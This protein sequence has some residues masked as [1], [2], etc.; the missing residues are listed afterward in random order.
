MLVEFYVVGTREGTGGGR[1]EPLGG[2][3]IGICNV[4]VHLPIGREIL[5]R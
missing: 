4:Y 5:N 2:R 1:V 3:Y